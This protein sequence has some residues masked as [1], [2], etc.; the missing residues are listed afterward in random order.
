MNATVTWTVT[1]TNSF[2]LPITYT[3]A[4]YQ[5]QS[6]LGVTAV[7]NNSLSPVCAGSPSNLSVILSGLAAPNYTLPVV[8]SPLFDEDLGNVTIS[9]GGV[10]I[11]NNT[12]VINSLNG[13]IGTATGTAGSYSNFTAFGPYTLLGAKCQKCTQKSAWN[14]PY[15]SSTNYIRTIFN[16][17]IYTLKSSKS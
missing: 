7:A 12:S 5:D 11:I 2:S 8:T 16:T 14:M 10:D 1:A 15:I 4:A 13:T 9:Q 17:F 3:G 6:L